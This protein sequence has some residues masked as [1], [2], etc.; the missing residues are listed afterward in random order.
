MSHLAG[1]AAV[2]A[3]LDRLPVGRFHYRMI[4]LIGA[5]LFLDSFEIALAA[6]VLGALLSD[7]WST[8]S[9][10][11]LF[12]SVTFAGFIVG[13][14]FSGILGDRLGRRFCYQIN[15]ALFGF[16][17]LAAAFTPNMELLIALRFIM[18]IGMGGE[19]VLGFAT[20][21]EFVPPHKRGR[22]VALLSFIAQSA[23][24]VC[25]L[26]AMWVIPNLGWRWMF[27]LVGV[28][29]IAIWLARKNM[30]ESPRWL[31]SRGRHEEA[32]AIVDDIERQLGV[33]RKTPES[34]APVSAPL[35]RSSVTDLLRP[36]RRRVLGVGIAI[37]VIIQICLYGF[38]SWIPT[39][40]VQQGMDIVKSLHW[41]MVMTLGGPAGGILALL[42]VD[43]VGR[44]GI[45][46]VAA[47]VA[48]ALGML[49]PRLGVESWVMLT[50]FLLLTAIYVIVVVGQAIYLSEL[51]PTR[52]RMRG[53][54]VCN[55]VAR[56]VATFIP[57]VVPALHAA[58]G[59]QLVTGV[60]SG[61]LV[62]FAL[63]VAFAGHET[64]K[65]SLE[66]SSS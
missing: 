33:P 53:T 42:L 9:L 27:G 24:F 60:L 47:V 4:F 39:L 3:R 11:S 49:Y 48:A 35:A 58:G 1:E 61:C 32:H 56:I 18:G 6:S 25:A 22:L 26:L 29:A 41:N 8:P 64:R 28:V 45:L 51:F 16:A 63:I 55:T 65:R 66:E 50:G 12:I 44:K 21:S 7:G 54:G 17:S 37:M 31:A 14:W 19:L 36:G 15:L 57:F 40:L 52:L 23:V 43:R 2:A 38:V 59:M 34:Q 5:G 30:A 13:A 62:A 46:V 20:L 10:N